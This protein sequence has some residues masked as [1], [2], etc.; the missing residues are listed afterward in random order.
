VVLPDENGHVGAVEI[1]DGTTKTVVDGAYGSLEMGADH[2]TRAL[3]ADSSEVARTFARAMAARPPGARMIIFF[4]ARAEPVRDLTGPIETLAAEIKEKANA[5]VAV[6]GHTD[7]LGS[8]AVNM[9][10]GLER[11]KLI[12]DRLVAAG[13]P[14]ERIRT[15][16]KGDTEPAVRSRSANVAEFRNR[17]VEVFLQ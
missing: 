5:V 14:R 16:S 13:I 10:L 6:V 4:T 7:E 9:R 17:R 12:A 2:R 1:D 3:A 8:H 11:A 15:S